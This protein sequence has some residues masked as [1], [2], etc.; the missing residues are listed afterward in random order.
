MTTTK[1]AINY[2]RPWL[3]PKQLDGLFHEKR[4]GIVEASTKAGKTVACIVWLGEEAMHGKEG[5]NYWW[6][7]PIY[8][9]AKI[10]FRRMKR[11]LPQSIYTANE[12]DLTIMFWN[13]TIIWFKSGL[14][15]DALFGEDVYAAVI[16]EATRVREESWQAIRTTLTA[17]RGPIRIIGNVKGR[18]NWAYTM[19]RRAESGEPDMHYA[20]ITAHDAV[21]AGV[22]HED[23]I[24][25]AKRVLPEAVF[26]ELYLA[27]PADDTG[28]PFGIE[29]IRAC[30]R[31]LSTRPSV[32]FG[33]DLA[34]SID[35][36]V[37]VGLD[38]F[39]VTSSFRRW[40]SPWTETEDRIR[41]VT[42]RTRALVDSTG[43]GDPILE[44]LQLVGGNYEGYKFTNTS[45]QQLMEGLAMG[46]QQKKIGFPEGEI[47]NELEEF[48]YEY[49][50]R[51]RVFYSA[52]RGMF[53][54]CVM[55]LA[56]AWHHG[57][58]NRLLGLP[59]RSSTGSGTKVPAAY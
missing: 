5:Y 55:G 20:K 16:D 31:P 25:D 34:K 2:T 21:E 17:T 30:I 37:G 52:P 50:S 11:M 33:W 10:A 36:V 27:E 59:E 54:D 47:V 13:G 43:V 58:S 35:W 14:D 29:A 53:D 8:S 6:I 12:S 1:R 23:E 42:G 28:N 57:T 9:Q 22:L 4:Y 51:G 46:I 24:A 48:E 40:Q 44:H 19:A 26:R 45:K 18:K 7:A 15:P 3:Y 56:L 41:G 39:G 38:R 32:V 49:G